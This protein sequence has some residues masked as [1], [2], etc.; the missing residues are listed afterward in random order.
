MT[1]H[2]KMA[3]AIRALSMDA[4]QKAQSG[5]PGAPL[6]MADIAEVLW[7]E[8]LRHNPNNPQWPDRDRFV[9]S[10]GHGSMLLYALLHLTGYDLSIE[11]IKNFR[12]M[13]SRT[14]GHPER[15]M[16]P[17]VETTTGPLGQGLA[18]AVG[19]AMAERILAA[20]FNRDKYDIVN[21]F[22][23]VFLG[24]GCLMEG[25]SHE[26][27]SLA[28][29]LGLG[30]LVAFYDDNQ[31]SIDGNVQGW[32]TD[33]TPARFEAYGW[34]VVR[35]VDGHDAKDIR[36]AI[37]EARA[38]NDHPS[39]LCCKTVI[40]YGAPNV[41]GSEHCHGSPLGDAEVE[42]T[43]KNLDWPHPAFVVPEPLQVGWDARER[44]NFF[45]KEW[46]GKFQDYAATYPE[47]AEEFTR[48][49]AGNLPDDFAQHALDLITATAKAGEKLATR[50]ASQKAIEFF[51]PKLP[52]LL[53]GSAD[54]AASNLTKWSGA[55]PLAN[56]TWNGD[57]V[58][59]GVREFGMA[60]IMNGMALHG[61]FIPFGGT[62][63]VFSDYSR[64]ALRMAAMMDLRVIH[65]LTHDSIGVGEDGPTHQP[66]EHMASLRMIPNLAV[67]R[68]CDAV[69][70]A[71]AWIEALK[72]D[73]GPTAL[74]LS[75]QGLA[76]QER[77]AAALADI[78]RGGYVLQDCEGQPDAILM[79][80]G[81]E[82][83]VVTKAADLLSGKGVKVRVV[84]MPCI[85]VFDAQDPEYKRSV[86][87]SEVGVR[88]AV[89]AGIPDSWHHLV[90][91]AG[92][93]LGMRRFGESAP[94]DQLF[95]HFGF[96][97]QLV[98]RRLEELLNR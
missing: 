6:G 9:L 18:N 55:K 7:N 76:H 34:H 46:R 80:S 48:R 39:L 79:S 29:T 77:T 73:S 10:N 33:D 37:L 60:A 57:Y 45:E 17:G 26:A 23:Y 14:P 41:C 70:T 98:T 31:I 16:T 95:A 54:L 21:H 87:P 1:H 86:M 53:G 66:I 65:V 64:N 11:D 93:V 38:V 72:N 78:H 92:D 62:F 69:E 28:G 75:R 94:G 4:I 20:H 32:F 68:P 85:Q 15:G 44:G 36:R 40:G 19:M 2:R 35:D 67:W 3:N 58:Y 59:Y 97:P 43:R 89:E 61:G 13:G 50:K 88:L 42:A 82:V 25:I 71:Q 84:S 27:C 91:Q 12:Q 90:G 74:I 51:S 8:F 30:K 49:M 56:T 22:T 81:S 83:E 63:L 24:D 96:T 5:H 47:M 52:E